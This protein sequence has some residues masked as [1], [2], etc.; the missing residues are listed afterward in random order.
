MLSTQE[1][2]AK[3]I[4]F[5][6]GDVGITPLVSLPE[7]QQKEI[8]MFFP[9][10]MSVI[11][12]IVVL[13]TPTMQIMN[14][15]VMSYEIRHGEERLR[16]IGF[17]A[18]RWLAQKGVEAV[19][20]VPG[21]PM[22]MDRWGG[23][24]WDISHK[25]I[26]VAAGLGTMGTNRNV[27]H[28]KYGAHI[29]LNTLLLNVEFD[30]YDQPLEKDVCLKCNLCIKICPV[31]SLSPTNLDFFKCFN[32]V[33]R[34]SLAGFLD[35]ISSVVESRGL[36]D[37]HN[38]W[39]ASEVMKVW[40][41]L[42]TGGV[43][44]CGFCQAVCPAHLGEKYSKIK[45]EHDREM[46]RRCDEWLSVSYVQRYSADKRLKEKERAVGG[47]K[48]KIRL[49][50]SRLKVVTG[51]QAVEALPL[52]FNPAAARGLSAVIQFNLTGDGGGRWYITIRN[53]SCNATEGQCSAPTLIINAPAE[54]WAKIAR[55]EINPLW[56]IIT[57]RLRFKGDIKLLRSLND[58]FPVPL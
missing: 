15:P 5:G 37:F 28:P 46:L 32:N 42:T 9:P 48:R 25:P 12:Y 3:M 57:R 26:A 33:Y 19:I 6:A 56:A 30:Q 1:V 35:F 52:L 38:K 44:S 24:I 55:R 8:K 10:S 54:V 14:L 11:S 31:G 18:V 16:E 29:L 2:K 53:Q 39:S 21:F 45:E 58:I 49:V 40:Q 50:R 51:R 17:K 23:K 36:K 13:H 20:T 47:G 27:L 34:H 41:S 43:Y 22:S 7:Q 4:E